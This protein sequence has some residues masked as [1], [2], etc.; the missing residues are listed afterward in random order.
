SEQDEFCDW[1]KQVL[2]GVHLRSDTGSGAYN[3]EW[4][5]QQ[6]QRQQSHRGEPDIVI[7]AARHN[8]HAL[9]IEMKP[10]GF[11]LRMQR[12]GHKIRV[13]KDRKGRVIGSDYKVR[14][15]GDWVNLHVEEQ[16]RCLEDYNHAGYL[17]RFAVGLDAAKKL[18]RYY[19]DLP[20]EDT[21]E[22]F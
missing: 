18:V 20:D 14:K 9:M 5:K 10:T 6:H 16:A 8:F 12:D 17:A 22:L 21:A 2:P 3:S 13:Y 19:F 1:F 7:Y 4:A 11:Q 15:K